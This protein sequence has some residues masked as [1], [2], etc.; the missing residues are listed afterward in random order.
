MATIAAVAAIG[1]AGFSAWS[2]GKSAKKQQAMIKAQIAEAQRIREENKGIANKSFDDII[3]LIDGTKSIGDYLTEGEKIGQ[4]QLDYR[5]KYVLGDT[6]GDVRDAQR[7]NANLAS[8]DFA[9]VNKSISDLIKSNLYDVASL[10]RDSPSGS[11]ANLS[12]QNM[13][14]LSQQGLANTINTGDFIGRISGIDQY[15]PYR[16]AQD[17]FSV[18]RD[19]SNQKIQAETNRSSQIIGTNNQWFTNFSDLSNASMVVEANRNAAMISAVNSAAGAIGGYGSAMDS[20]KQQNKQNGYYQS[21]L[22][23]YSTAG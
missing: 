13:A 7:I 19:K 23:K 16:I 4:A 14:A 9:D 5:M 20:E 6:E 17:L 2:S 1:A 3:G 18:E 10:T 15:T 12:V 8:Y 11:F 21:L 22:N